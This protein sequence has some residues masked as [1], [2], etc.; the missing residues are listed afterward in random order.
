MNV[1]FNWLSH[2]RCHKK[3][4][5]SLSNQEKLFLQLK[6]IWEVSVLNPKP[7]V[8]D[9][10]SGWRKLKRSMY[11]PNQRGKKP[12]PVR[13]KWLVVMQPRYGFAIL[14][15]TFMILTGVWVYHQSFTQYR[16]CRSVTKSITLRDGTE[17]I[18][19]SDS[20]LIVLRNFNQKSR[21]VSLKGEAYF[22]VAKNAIPFLV[23]THTTTIKVLGT[24][25]N[26]FSRNNKVE[27]AVNEGVV[28]FRSYT[29]RRDSTVI[30][31]QGQ[32][33][34]CRKDDYPNIPQAIGFHQ[35]PGWLYHKIT[36][37][38]LELGAI[39]KE[40]EIRFDVKIQLIDETIAS[41]TISGVFDASSLDR[42]LQVICTLIEKDYNREKKKIIIS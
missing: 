29:S 31:N 5:H 4:N 13:P 32:F 36:A 18:L 7:E 12:S 40:I 9:V 37:N 23:K 25:F 39:L 30:L 10:K 1:F 38:H 28:V 42:L 15:I 3:E 41:R 22:K 19:N 33:A 24:E 27:V 34:V 11:Q 17:I 14:S 21:N 6:K 26:I 2:N 20:K 16:A 8:P 35:Y